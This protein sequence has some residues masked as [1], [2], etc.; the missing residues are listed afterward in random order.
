MMW[1][2]PVLLQLPGLSG[3]PVD[4]VDGLSFVF[5]VMIMDGGKLFN[6][7]VVIIYTIWRIWSFLL[8]LLIIKFC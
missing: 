6:Y 1:Q 7:D 8:F 2:G 4:G 3:L 5:L